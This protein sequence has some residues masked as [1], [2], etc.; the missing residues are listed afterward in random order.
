MVINEPHFKMET[1]TKD[2]G[3]KTIDMEKEVY[4]QKVESIIQA[5]GIFFIKEK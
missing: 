3:V 1:D 2:I 4:F 5:T